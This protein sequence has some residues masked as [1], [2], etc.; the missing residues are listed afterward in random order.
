MRSKDFSIDGSLVIV[1]GGNTGIGKE[2]AR[3]LS[4]AGAK[5][6]IAC[7]NMQKAEEAS[8]EITALSQNPVK[9]MCLDLSVLSSVSG[10]SEKFLE[11]YGTPDVLVNNAAVYMR[12]YQET[13]FG[14]EITMAVNYLAPFYLSNLFLPHMAALDGETRIVNVTSEA[15]H[16][17]EFDPVLSTRK[18]YK[19]F[20]AYSQS[21]R[22]L[23]YFT[24]E[25]A[26]KIKRTSV[27][28]NCVNPGHAATNIWPSDAI[29]WK[30]ARGIISMIA[31]PPSYAA[32]N[33]VFTAAS[34]EM[35]GISGKYINNLAIEEPKKDSFDDMTSHELWENTLRYLQNLI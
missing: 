5:V 18:H 13:P 2:T 14:M 3:K 21:K 34:N 23:M 7:R 17:K 27:T 32:E 20:S 22:A 9:P 30:A 31:D 16:I 29:H 8:L 24:F 28:V 10:F 35:N 11:V 4:S 19:G 15:Y 25:M 6:I 26:E 1:T 33:V 12:K